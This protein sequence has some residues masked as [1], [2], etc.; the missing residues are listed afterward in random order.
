MNAF[1]RSLYLKAH[2]HCRLNREIN[3]ENKEKEEKTTNS[4]KRNQMNKTRSINSIRWMRTQNTGI[5]CRLLLEN[6]HRIFIP[7][8]HENKVNFNYYYFFFFFKTKIMMNLDYFF[9]HFFVFVVVWKRPL[10]DRKSMH[11]RLKQTHWVR[12]NE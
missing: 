2:T 11:K 10:D 5:L 6:L 8:S 4:E 3:I 7:K 9:S 12:M 1:G